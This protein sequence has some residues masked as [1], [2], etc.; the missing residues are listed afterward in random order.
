MECGTLLRTHAEPVD[1]TADNHLRQVPRYDLKNGADGVA[2]EAELNGPL[3]AQL[4]AQSEG[5]D[6]AAEGAELDS[7]VS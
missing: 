3:A 6:G 5:K 7:H 4:V 1:D 2:D